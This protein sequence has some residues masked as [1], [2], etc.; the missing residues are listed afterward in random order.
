MTRLEREDR[1]GHTG[2]HGER[3]KLNH[4]GTVLAYYDPGEKRFIGVAMKTLDGQW[5]RLPYEIRANG[6]LPYTDT[7]FT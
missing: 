4:A 6:Q 5:V 7:D 1:D 3:C 2:G